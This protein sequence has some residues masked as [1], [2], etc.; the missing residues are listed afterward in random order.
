M[1]RSAREVGSGKVSERE[2]ERYET[3]REVRQPEGLSVGWFPTLEKPIVD[4]VTMELGEKVVLVS[5]SDLQDLGWVKSVWKDNDSKPKL[6]AG[7][8]DLRKTLCE[9]HVRMG[10]WSAN[11]LHAYLPWHRWDFLKTRPERF[12]TQAT[13]PNEEPLKVFVLFQQR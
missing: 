9:A 6:A 8:C 13:A 12:L 2:G 7:S 4:R 1:E 11:C 3:E 10:G 5:H